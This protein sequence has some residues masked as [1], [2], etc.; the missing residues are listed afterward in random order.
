MLSEFDIMFMTQKAI[1]G[2]A[3]SNYLAD[4]SLNNLDVLEPLFLDKDVLAMDP[5]LGNV[6][7]QCWKLYFNGAANSIGNGVGVE[8]QLHQ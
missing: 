1:K 2:Q 6:E 7:P 8:F 5:S 3:I 4:Q